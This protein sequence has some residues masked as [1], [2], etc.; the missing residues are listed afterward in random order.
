MHDRFVITGYG[1][2]NSIGKNAKETWLASLE[3]KSKTDFIKSWDPKA[4]PAF[5]VYRANQCDVSD[6]LHER[7]F[8]HFPSLTKAAFI[9]VDE[10]VN[11]A[12]LKS[13]KVATIISSIA[14]GNDSRE[15][16]EKDWK[17]GRKKSN[18]FNA[19]GVS[20]DY[21]ATAISTHYK[22][23]GPSTVMVS[24][25]ASGIYSLDYAIKCIRAGDCDYAVVGGTDMMADMYDM[26]FFQV[27][28]AL[29]KRDEE[30][31]SQPFSDERDGIVM[32]EGAGVFVVET[33]A[34]AISRGA[35]ILAE[36]KGIGFYTECEHPTS[37]SESGTGAIESSRIA[38]Q[39]SGLDTV[40]FISAHATSTVLGDI[41][42]YEAMN[43]MF[44]N[45]Y[46]TG[47]KGHLGHTMSASAIIESIISIE[48]MHRNIVPPTANFTQC[49]FEKE[50]KIVKEATPLNIDSFMKNSY[51]FGGKCSS[52]IYQKV[53]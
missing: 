28:Q 37:P 41:V 29:S 3:T 16:L 33:M 10:A 23:T 46:I 32:G 50:L 52:V 22:W 4:D 26:Y 8:R 35:T 19:L 40:D 39:R 13:N 6:V 34:N 47:S 14:G 30:Y 15:K 20:Y 51:G 38:L 12:N 36:I 9:A 45:S 18:P 48:G 31:I 17:S 27:L 42:E 53:K 21:T 25:C 1:T 43:K 2:I 24:A 49:S 7:E 5:T 11:M 44:P